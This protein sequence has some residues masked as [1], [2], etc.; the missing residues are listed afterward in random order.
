MALAEKDPLSK[1]GY[2]LI[3]AVVWLMSRIPLPV[4]QFFGRMLG[5]IFAA[6]GTRRINSS[7]ENLNYI[8]G[9]RMGEGKIYRLNKRVLMHFGEMLFE[10]PHILRLSHETLDRYV[11]FENE[12]NLLYAMRKGKGV[13]VLTGHFGN[14]ELMSAA[15]TLCFAPD[16]A[17][18]ARPID[19]SILDRLIN[20]LRSRFGAEVIPKQR[21]MKSLL[22]AARKNKVVGILLDQNVDW[23]EGVFVQFLG[24]QACTS[25]GLALVAQKTGSSVV[26]A[27]SVRQSDGRYRVIFEK[28]LELVNTGDKIRDLEENTALFSNIIEKY[29]R[30]YPDHWFWFHRRWKTKS[31][32]P[33]PQKSH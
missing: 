24:R 22:M 6:L 31:Y 7:L 23:Y 2:A 1:I 9:D 32:C 33:F 27:F 20:H 29:V 21:A 14:W 26:P 5:R 19:F 8:F 3:Y 16:G 28:E 13:F 10:V 15:I 11:V 18:V 30:Q 12:E 17:I 25:K 4:G